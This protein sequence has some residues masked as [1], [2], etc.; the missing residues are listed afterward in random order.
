MRVSAFIDGFNF[1]HAVDAIGLHHLKWL[2]LRALCREFAPAPDHELRAV[3]YF[4]AYATWRPGPYARHRAY[5]KALATCG[6]RAVLGRFKEKDR[7]CWSCQKS[8]KDHEEKETDVN[9]ALYLLRD[10]FDDQYDRALIVSGDS[11]LTPAVRMV[12]DRFPEKEIRIIAPV[13]RPYSMELVGAAGGRSQGVK[14][15][16]I[17]LER[18]LLPR[19]VLDEN[20]VLVSTRP[21]KYDPPPTA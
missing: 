1:Y 15:A 20:G 5:L 17:H 11:D 19:E 6:V 12:R 21:P 7:S 3:Y 9:I 2:N 16:R 8:W 18:S 14:M 4:T 10:A 13:G